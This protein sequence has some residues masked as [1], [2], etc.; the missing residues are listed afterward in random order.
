VNNSDYRRAIALAGLSILVLAF[1]A[2]TFFN[3]TARGAGMKAIPGLYAVVFFV[4]L[5]TLAPAWLLGKLQ[6]GGAPARL[7]GAALDRRDAIALVVALAIGGAI[8][9]LSLV[10]LLLSGLDPRQLH[11]LFAGLLVASI[12]EVM[13]FLGVLAPVVRALLGRGD[14]WLSRLAIVIVSSAGFG[15]FHFTYPEPWN[16]LPTALMLGGLWLL[17]STLFVMSRSLLAAILLDNILATV[18]FVRSHL[19]L[20]VSPLGGWI[21]AVIAVAGFLLVMRFSRRSRT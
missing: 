7:L 11:G 15:L 19:T 2:N 14:D 9:S 12:A 6:V 3:H 20:P 4:G 13:L 5:G 10:P 8:A 18:G 21:L 17:T 1:A 16:T